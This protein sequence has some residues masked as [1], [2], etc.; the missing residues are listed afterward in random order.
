MDLNRIHSAFISTYWSWSFYSAKECPA[1]LLELL[2]EKL[3]HLEG[4]G[5]EKRF[6]WGGVF[7]NGKEALCDTTLTAP[8][9]IEYYEPNFNIDEAHTYFPAFEQR[10]IVYED[11][12]LIVL[13]KPAKLPSVAGR[14]QKHFNLK[15][16]VET[17]LGRAVHCPSRLDMSTEGLV[18]MSKSARTNAALQR[19]FEKK[20]IQKYYLLEVVGD[21][22]QGDLRVEN[23]IGRDMRH[24]VLRKVVESGGKTAETIFTPVGH[25][26]FKDRAAAEHKTT[27]VQ[28]RPLTGRTHQIRVH[29]SHVGFPIIGDDFYGGAA[30]SGLR[31]QSR[32]IV[33]THPWL[34]K[35]LEITAPTSLSPAWAC[36]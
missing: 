9:K 6:A 29:A 14:E 21:F 5:W 11:E 32:K 15:N 16:Y 24:P 26:L 7:V 10:L 25:S 34:G 20:T 3:P 30:A 13:Y 2:R 27:L 8:C 17:Y 33:L 36:V 19:A 28:A 35:K 31:L 4:S 22:P 23:Q 18:I 1:T 12:D